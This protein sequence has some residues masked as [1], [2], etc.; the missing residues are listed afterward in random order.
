MNALIK[1]AKVIRIVTVAPLIAFYLLSITYTV[2]PELYQ[3]LKNYL[4]AVF[5]LTVLPL[6]A[7]PLQ[8]F[9]P[10]FKEKGRE[11]QRN[12]AIVMAITGYICGMVYVL[13][14]R[15]SCAVLL[16]YL[17]Y[18]YSGLGILLFNKVL[19]IQASGHAGGVVGP[20]ALLVWFVG[21]QAV[22]YCL[23]LIFLV[24]WASLKMQ[25]HNLFQLLWGS[26]I[27]LV[28]LLLA[29]LCVGI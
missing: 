24:Y 26:M 15:V 6:S 19:K 9:I 13:L 18:F 25:R 28:A 21:K 11:G 29:V 2:R 1:F 4:T 5:F 17:T 14:A 10:K 27:P 16:I 22:I 12:L 8:P 20:T 23:V 7:Y 3:G